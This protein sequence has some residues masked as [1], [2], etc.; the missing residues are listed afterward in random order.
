MS[1]AGA[2]GGAPVSISLLHEKA[3]MIGWLRDCRTNNGGTPDPHRA[4]EQGPIRWS[5]RKQA[6]Q[7]DMK[8]SNTCQEAI[9]VKRHGI[10]ERGTRRR[11]AEKIEI[12]R[13]W[14]GGGTARRIRFSVSKIRRMGPEVRRRCDRKPVWAATCQT[15]TQ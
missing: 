9:L 1:S 10:R 7:Q 13:Q 15:K 3:A 12:R 2:A 11:D 6:L 4:R 14:R 8:V 5:V